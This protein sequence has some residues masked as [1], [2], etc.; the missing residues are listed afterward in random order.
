MAD[1]IDTDYSGRPLRPI[2]ELEH[3]P[4]PIPEDLLIMVL[5]DGTQVAQWGDD[6]YYRIGPDGGP[7]FKQPVDP[8]LLS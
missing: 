2:E 3:D 8:K 5:E 1:V 6:E 7:D 4:A